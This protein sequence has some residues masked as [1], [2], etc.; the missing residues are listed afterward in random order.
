MS[1]AMHCR[2]ARATRAGVGELAAL[3][4]LH[5]ELFMVEVLAIAAGGVTA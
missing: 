4:D 2:A 5:P 3:V 1:I